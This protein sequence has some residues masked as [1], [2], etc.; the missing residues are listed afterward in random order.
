MFCENCGARLDD[1]AKFCNRCG[2]RIDAG[3]DQETVWKNGGGKKR[4]WD[5]LI[6]DILF[7]RKEEWEPDDMGNEDDEKEVSPPFVPP[8]DLDGREFQIPPVPYQPPTQQQ[9]I[10]EDDDD[11]TIGIDPE[12]LEER[13]EPAGLLRLQVKS[14]GQIYE[15]SL[16]EPLIIG[17]DEKSCSIV[18]S[19]NK[20]IS[21]QHCRLYKQNGVCYI[22]DLESYNHTYVNDEEIS[23]PVS[24]CVGDVV[25]L[26]LMEFIVVEIDMTA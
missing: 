20:S 2:S 22:Q 18:I 17:R 19:G 12:L 26:G 1:D 5:I 7:K 24:L 25:R 6:W 16:A 23:E 13:K 8:F 21:R 14:S 4:I 9:I 3:Q 15:C 11:K 10:M